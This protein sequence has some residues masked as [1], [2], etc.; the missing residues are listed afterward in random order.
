[1]K[2]N[3]NYDYYRVA[4]VRRAI[5]AQLARAIEITDELV[6]AK[7]VADD[8]AERYAA[9]VTETVDKTMERLG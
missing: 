7:K 1:M 5:A 9:L 3:D 6:E 2:N 4:A 8:A